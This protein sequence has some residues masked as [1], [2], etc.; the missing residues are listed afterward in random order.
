MGCYG[1][2]RLSI[3]YRS[4]LWGGS[5]LRIVTPILATI[6]VLLLASMFGTVNAAEV[7]KN[8]FGGITPLNTTGLTAFNNSLKRSFDFESDSMVLSAEFSILETNGDVRDFSLFDNDLTLQNGPQ[9]EDST[10]RNALY[11]DGPG[12]TEYASAAH[13]E[14]LDMEQTNISIVWWGQLRQNDVLQFILGKLGRASPGPECEYNYGIYIDSDNTVGTVISDD[15]AGGAID[16]IDSELPISGLRT[17]Q[18][19]GIGTVFE[20]TVSGAEIHIW[21]DGNWIYTETS[22]LR[23]GDA[24]L[25]FWVARMQ[26][27]PTSAFCNCTHD[28]ILV[29]QERL[30]NSTMQL[31][32]TKQHDIVIKAGPRT[33]TQGFEGL[34]FALPWLIVFGLLGWLGY[35]IFLAW[36]EAFT[37]E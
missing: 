37:R 36:K 10:F 11:T 20:D 27:G 14:T 34:F 15:C 33:T 24:G 8:G 21:L 7:H 9:F 1:I 25:E 16:F 31:L 5:I 23:V 26:G 2:Y 17:N 13:S 3:H 6:A 35:T 29:F 19:Y 4:N 18:T 30:D 32:T 28:E 22:T 12:N